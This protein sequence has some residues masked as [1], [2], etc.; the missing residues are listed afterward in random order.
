VELILAEQVL[1]LALDDE[2]GSDRPSYGVDPGLSGALLMDLGRLEVV[3]EED[4]KIVAAEGAASPAQPLLAEALEAIRDSDKQRSAKGW[5]D[6]LPKELKPLRQRLAEGSR[7]EGRAH[8]EAAQGARSL[9]E[10]A[11]SRG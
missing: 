1:L 9:P 5:V 3:R 10:H 6:R 4:G 7:R 8:R 2:K 11:L